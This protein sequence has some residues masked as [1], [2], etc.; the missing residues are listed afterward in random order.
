MWVDLK[1]TQARSYLKSLLDSKQSSFVSRLKADN[2]FL[3][4]TFKM[5]TIYNLKLNVK[6]TSGGKILLG[7]TS[8][9]LR[10]LYIQFPVMKTSNTVV[11]L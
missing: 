8:A 4:C 7:A 6:T 9:L 1:L 2:V 5:F 3:S 11:T 10:C